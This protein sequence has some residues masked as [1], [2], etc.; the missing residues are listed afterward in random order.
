MFE[1]PPNDGATEP[2]VLDVKPCAQR[3]DA[4]H[5]RPIAAV[6]QAGEARRQ[7]LG[8]HVEPLV[9]QI[10]GRTPRSSFPIQGAVLQKAC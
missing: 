2:D 8:Q 3:P 9:C 5:R 7:P 4:R 6:Q 10:D 1:R